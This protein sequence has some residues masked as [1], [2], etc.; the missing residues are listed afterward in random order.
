[1]LFFRLGFESIVKFL[2]D[3]QAE[4]D[5]GDNYGK[6]P[7]QNAAQNGKKKISATTPCTRYFIQLI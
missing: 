5:I 2:I 1:M 3:S 4:I 7:L 6:I